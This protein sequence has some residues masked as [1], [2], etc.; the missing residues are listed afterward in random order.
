[1][2][3]WGE[4]RVSWRNLVPPVAIVLALVCVGFSLRSCLWPPSNTVSNDEWFPYYADLLKSGDPGKIARGITGLGELGDPKAID[5]IRPY[6]KSEDPRVVAAAAVALGELGDKSATDTL[7]ELLCERDPGI[8]ASAA[9][10]LGALKI[11]QAVAPMSK[12][13]DV[14]DYTV[15]KAAVV[16][17][18]EIGDPAAEGALA[19]LRFSPCAGISPSP[20]EE[21]CAALDDAIVKAIEKIRNP[22]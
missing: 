8:L 2:P 13:L 22:K 17:L 20:S 16:A 12:L 3:I 7:I 9:K 4:F 21:D 10:G 5:L 14:P 11:K 6:L 18:G 15:R 1:M 19:K